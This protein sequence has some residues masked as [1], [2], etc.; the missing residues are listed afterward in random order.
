MITITGTN[1]SP[2]ITT[3]AGQAVG[4][5]VEAGN[6]DNGTVVP[7]TPVVS[8]QLSSSDVDDGAT[9]TWSGSLDSPYGAFAITAAGAWT[10]TLDNAA[11]QALAE[12]V[13]A[14]ETFTVTV[15]DDFGATAQQNVV[16]TI[17]GTNDSPDLR[18]VTTDTISSVQ[19]ET[20]A[21]LTASGTLTVTDPDT[22]DT[23]ASSVTSVTLG[24]TTGS[25]ASAAVL[26]MLS[27]APV[28]GLAANSG[29]T[30]NLGWA[31]SS[32]S[33]AFDYLGAGQSLTLTYTVTISDGHGGTD[34]QN[35]TVTINGTNDAAVISGTSTGSVIEAGTT[36]GGGTPT[37]MGTLTDTDVDN[38][39]NTF[40]AS[41]GSA[42][43]GTYA[44]TIG[45]VWTYTLNNANAAVNALNVGG[46]LSD[47]FV[48]TTIDGT[49][50]TVN[51]TIAGANDAAVISGAT[52]GSVTEDAVPNT[53]GGDLNSTDVDGATDAWTAVTTATASANGYGSFTMD[54]TG[55]WSYAL[56]NANAAVNALNT[57][58]TLN[59]SFTVT[60]ADGT[61]QIVTVVI[62]GVTDVAVPAP[63]D[64]VFTVTAAG[65]N[66]NGAPNGDF[67]QLS[68]GNA[69]GGA[70]Y[71][72]GATNLT[73]TTLSGGVATNV[74][75][76]ITVNSSGVVT[77]TSVDVD[78][79]Y[80]LTVQVTNGGN[81]YNETFSI[82]VGTNSGV[83]TINGAYISGDDAIFAVG[84]DDIVFAGSGNDT[85]FGQ[86]GEDKIHGGSGN[87]LLF[88]AA[89]KDEFYF[90]TALNSS[91]NVD[92]IKDFDATNTDKIA[93]D[94]AI[95][96]ALGSSGTRNLL[97]AN[98]ASNAG[99]NALDA[100]DFI[101]FDSATGNLFYDA[102]GSGAGAKVLFAQ[103]DLSGLVGG[104]AGVDVTDFFII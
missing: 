62:N 100:N 18:A 33:Q 79:V 40:T 12:G 58:G 38:P 17:T 8:G 1:D 45:G 29:D 16:I 81:S 39:T 103:L 64:L 26:G 93:L 66:G 95:F 98:F 23:I 11:A 90:D 49:Q 13:S 28:S 75:G 99:G 87:D 2:V 7:G 50:K 30:H 47:S 71:T 91:S 4:T 42:T 83:D 94:D 86:A 69:V 24:G 14:S 96:A 21:A 104:T 89:G 73:A 43:Y 52:T 3:A 72:Y 70:I 61:A 15:I 78:R 68:V 84:G 55:H 101:L 102:D 76:D 56:N 10:Y 36:N 48:V 35:I 46:S 5:V 51:V 77:G 32:G 74:A 41:A 6:L 20:N 60:T 27:V 57:G 37:A 44:M 65:I 54:A 31:F 19:T 82:V 53:V 88:G 92:V 67:A 97:V 25:L 34:T 9:A 22:T 85:V 80:E 63:N 59:D